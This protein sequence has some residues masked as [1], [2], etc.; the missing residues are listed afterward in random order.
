MS[1][2]INVNIEL[3]RNVLSEKFSVSSAS[4]GASINNFPSFTVKGQQ[5]SLNGKPRLISVREAI[6]L[7]SKF[8]KATFDSALNDGSQDNILSIKVGDISKE[9]DVCF[10]NYS[11]AQNLVQPFS[12]LNGLS[13]ASRMTIFDGSV[14]L[15][16][17]NVVRN[18][19]IFPQKV[20]DTD[21][22]S[23]A[24]MCSEILSSIIESTDNNQNFSSSIS[25][26]NVDRIKNIR[27][28]NKNAAKILNE[29]FANSIEET[30][31]ESL[32]NNTLRDLLSVSIGNLI[33]NAFLTAQ[34]DLT[35]GLFNVIC[36][37]FGLV[38][39]P[40]PESVG[41]LVRIDRILSSPPKKIRL[42]ISSLESTIG[43]N[44]PP[45]SAARMVSRRAGVRSIPNALEKP[46]ELP[47]FEQ[48]V[49]ALYPREADFTINA[50]IL[51]VRPPIWIE[52]N[53]ETNP[54]S[55]D[56]KTGRG[57]DFEAYKKSVESASAVTS[58]LTQ[59]IDRLCYEIVRLRYLQNVLS[60]SFVTINCPLYDN[61]IASIAV[62][63]H[64][65]IL[66]E[67]D[68]ANNRPIEIRGIVSGMLLGIAA[69]SQGGSAM[70]K[71]DL[72][73]TRFGNFSLPGFGQ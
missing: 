44:T 63:D 41:K 10:L 4:V 73:A 69:D 29:L 60:E 43:T 14:C 72:S 54:V 59:E 47:S 7:G 36:G 42:H 71:L 25:A 50:K 49:V 34:S 67:D 12:V 20:R 39:L 5:F 46:G 1:K 22:G 9:Y 17:N 32:R 62:G 66:L 13:P 26:A 53:T 8:Q 21:N 19:N 58:T 16:N 2:P 65:N 48:P 24:K 18:Q 15:V 38:Y 57:F 70:V 23:I 68:E 55:S 35:H 45:F 11:P 6:D 3:K 56:V 31:Y 51:D 37:E 30:V 64:L 27:N 33:A 40:D 52:A 61:E 28:K